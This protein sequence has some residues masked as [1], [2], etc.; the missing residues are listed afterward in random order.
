[1]IVIRLPIWKKVPCSK[2]LVRRVLQLHKL[3]GRRPQHQI[4]VFYLELSME[5]VFRLQMRAG[6]FWVWRRVDFSDDE[7]I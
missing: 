6:L 7:S 3:Y 4:E 2:F 5:R 1:M